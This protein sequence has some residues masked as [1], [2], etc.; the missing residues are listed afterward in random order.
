VGLVGRIR[1]VLHDDLVLVVVG[2]VGQIHCV[3]HDDLV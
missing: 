2:L 3:P 1:C